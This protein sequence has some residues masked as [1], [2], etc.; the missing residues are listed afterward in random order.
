MNT[1]SP[2]GGSR[3]TISGVFQTHYM[4]VKGRT[5]RAWARGVCVTGDHAWDLLDVQRAH[6][7]RGATLA[8]VT[9]LRRKAS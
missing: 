7:E 1:G 4:L 9:P 6:T 5:R 3:I 2:A 8:Q